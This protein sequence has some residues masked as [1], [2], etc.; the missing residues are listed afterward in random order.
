MIDFL[1]LVHVTR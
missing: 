1:S